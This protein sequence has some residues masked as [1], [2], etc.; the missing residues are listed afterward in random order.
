MDKKN[1]EIN[2]RIEKQF[3][4]RI[5]YL[6]KTTLDLLEIEARKFNIDEKFFDKSDKTNGFGKIRKNMFDHGNS[7][8][9]LLGIIMDKLEVVPTN[10]IIEFEDDKNKHKIN[11]E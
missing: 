2:N 5:N 10:A 7:M 3:G 6:F 8:I 1:I 4:W 11:N 9:E